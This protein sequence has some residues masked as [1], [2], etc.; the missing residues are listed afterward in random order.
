MYEPQGAQS[1]V[2]TPDYSAPEVLK[3]GV[4][5]IENSERRRSSTGK[6]RNNS[7]E[8]SASE[9][10][11]GKAADWWSL[12]VMIFEMIS[13][14]PPFRGK[15]LRETYKNVLFAEV[16]FVDETFSSS[17]ISLI[18]GLLERDPAKR[19]GSTTNPP[20][21]IMWSEFFEPLDWQQV[22]S[23]HVPGPISY[24]DLN[25]E[26]DMDRPSVTSASI[27]E[28]N[29]RDSIIAPSRDLRNK[30]NSIPDWSFMDSSVLTTVTPPLQSGPVGSKVMPR[31]S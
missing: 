16:K 23:R 28:I 12:G 20:S 8:I 21:D 1:L 29:T 31:L 13:G 22:Y 5:R 2:G 11:Y 7:L 24:V 9:V 6:K 25:S 10:G 3:T 19:L 4:Y 17:A 26:V 15:D 30:D 14:R 18:S 27:A